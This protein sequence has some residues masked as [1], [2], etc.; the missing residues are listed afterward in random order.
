VPDQYSSAPQTEE[1][2]ETAT[3]HVLAKVEGVAIGTVVWNGNVAALISGSDLVIL[4]GST[5]TRVPLP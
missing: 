2:R 5:V 4:D 1:L 3:G